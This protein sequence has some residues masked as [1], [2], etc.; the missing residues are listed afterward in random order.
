M[1]TVGIVTL[2]D[3][4]SRS[5]R[6]DIS[7]KTIEQLL[8]KERYR[9]ISYALLPDDRQMLK[10]ELIRLCDEEKCSFVFTTGGTGFSVR[11]ITPEATLEVAQKNA[12]GIAEAIRFY[13]LAITK[14]AMLSRG[15]SVIRG[16]TIII[17]LPGSPKA[18][19]ESL[20]FIIGTIE[21]GSDILTGSAVE[22][23]NEGAK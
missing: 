12:S 9:V 18:V 10:A 19:K 23:G 7:G 8:P 2:S 15:V 6:E 3:K 13:S 20:G 16:N 14:R 21:H 22:C 17:N 5:E 4:G 1:Y 11:D